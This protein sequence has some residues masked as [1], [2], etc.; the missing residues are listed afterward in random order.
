MQTIVP[1]LFIIFLM[2]KWSKKWGPNNLN[3]SLSVNAA[4]TDTLVVDP[5]ST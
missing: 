5:T 3:S 1:P 2:G 4:A